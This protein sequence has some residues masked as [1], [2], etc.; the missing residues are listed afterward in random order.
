MKFN[1]TTRGET[2]ISQKNG[3]RSIKTVISKN[4]TKIKIIL[5]TGKITVTKS[6]IL[7]EIMGV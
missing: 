3:F 7:W 5:S 6:E 4:G 2:K 1:A